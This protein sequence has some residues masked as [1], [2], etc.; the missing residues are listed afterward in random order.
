VIEGAPLRYTQ[1][2][3][4]CGP[5]CR[6]VRKVCADE[7]V[8]QNSRCG[9]GATGPGSPNRS[10]LATVDAER[11]ACDQHHHRA[12]ASRRNGRDHHLPS[13][14]PGRRPSPAGGHKRPVAPAGN[15]RSGPRPRRAL[16][17]STTA[18]LSIHDPA[19]ERSHLNTRPV[20]K[21]QAR[22]AHHRRK[23]AHQPPV[24]R[25]LA[26]RSAAQLPLRPQSRRKIRPTAPIDLA[27]S[28]VNRA[29]C[30]IKP[31]C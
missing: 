27:N 31:R 30:S 21:A 16:A 29:N 6:A 28:T 12:D 18:A 4:P 8:R 23:P 24:S 25:S 20:L 11:A 15:P 9:A 26:N 22:R 13:S 17:C 3:N 14:I 5:K 1:T 10:Q 2:N 7:P 19:P